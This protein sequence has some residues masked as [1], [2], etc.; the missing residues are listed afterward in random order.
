MYSKGKKLKIT[1][2]HVETDVE[3]CGPEGDRYQVY[4]PKSHGY[5]IVD[6]DTP[7]TKAT[8]TKRKIT[9]DKPND[10]KKKKVGKPK[11]AEYKDA[12]S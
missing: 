5:Y 1:I 6:L 2:D 9:T 7:K 10:L 12:W 3:Y 4:D 8:A 11:A